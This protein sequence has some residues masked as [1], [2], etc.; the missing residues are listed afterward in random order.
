MTDFQCATVAEPPGQ[1]Y[2]YPPSVLTGVDD[3]MLVMAEETSDPSLRSPSHRGAA[4]RPL[5]RP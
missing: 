2:F 5:R 4:A 1:G 3:S